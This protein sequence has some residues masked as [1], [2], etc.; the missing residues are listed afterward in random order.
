MANRVK[1]GYEMMGRKGYRPVRETVQVIYEANKGPI[2]REVFKVAD[3]A[4]DVVRSIV[5]SE[6]PFTNSEGEDFVNYLDNLRTEPVK[7]FERRKFARGTSIPVSLVSVEGASLW[8]V[9]S[10]E[11]GSG[12]SRPGLYPM[13]K[14]LFE[15][16]G[17]T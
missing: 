6:T 11:Y 7:E 13:T 14:A 1:A 2:D 12:N 10:I 17:K 16:G 9:Q 3:R 15:M 4:T 5:S 8:A